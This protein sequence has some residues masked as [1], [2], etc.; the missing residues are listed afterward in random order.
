[1]ESQGFD[2]QIFG[3]FSGPLSPMGAKAIIAHPHALTHHG[4]HPTQGH[5]IQVML[6]MSG[7]PGGDPQQQRLPEVH[8]LLPGSPKLDHYKTISYDARTGEYQPNGQYSPQTI[9][10]N[11]NKSD[12]S[13]QRIEYT[14]PDGMQQVFHQPPSQQQQQQQHLQIA[15]NSPGMRKLN[16]KMDA[17]G[18][19]TPN[20]T[21]SST[22]SNDAAASSTT[23]GSNKSKGNENK[24]KGKTDSN[25]VKKKKTRWVS[26]CVNLGVLSEF[27]GRRKIRSV[28]HRIETLMKWKS[29]RL[30]EFQVKVK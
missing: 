19:S 28:I 27:T 22:S 6:G 10:V 8:T 12:Y 9:H 29:W 18:A 15:S 3:E 16:E 11:G 21:A 20:T 7:H 5:S 1:M 2:D 23:N 13:P 4:H 17:S 26:F 14:S 25:G 30:V 24:G